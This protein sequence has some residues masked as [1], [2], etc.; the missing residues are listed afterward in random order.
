M[1]H[2]GDVIEVGSLVDGFGRPDRPARWSGGGDR[3]I[4]G[5]RLSRSGRRGGLG[6]RAW[7]NRHRRR[8][9]GEPVGAG[10]ANVGRIGRYRP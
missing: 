5:R 2:A 6:G 8:R 7:R 3:R 10:V 4:D 9:G 1:E